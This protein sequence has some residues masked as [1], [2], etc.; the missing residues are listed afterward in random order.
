[1][2]EFA[3]NSYGHGKKV[4]NPM[5][6]AAA[7]SASASAAKGIARSAASH[8]KG[9]T[10]KMRDSVNDAFTRGQNVVSNGLHFVTRKVSQT[11]NHV[12]LK[13]EMNQSLN[14]HNAIAAV[15]TAFKDWEQRFPKKLSELIATV[16]KL[17]NEHMKTAALF[18]KFPQMYETDILVQ[19]SIQE[20]GNDKDDCTSSFLLFDMK[21]IVHVLQRFRRLQRRQ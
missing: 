14:V 2:A 13:Q 10:R 4:L 11:K 8:I 15:T 1:M 5:V 6:S 7:S 9:M 16:H 20:K 3:K 19:L 18:F 17:Y 12:R 21:K